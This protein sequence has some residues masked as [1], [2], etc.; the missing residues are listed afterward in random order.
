LADTSI[1]VGV[2]MTHVD[3]KMELEG[4]VV[5]SK[6]AGLTGPIDLANL[7]IADRP[8][9]DFHADFYKPVDQDGLRIG[10][11]TGSLCGGEI[12][13]NVDL[14]FPET[15]DSRYVM[16]LVLR[17]ADVR[18][19]SG[20]KDENLSGELSVTMSLEGSWP[21]PRTRRGRGDVQVTGKEMYK[22]PLVLGLLQITN[23]SLPITAPFTDGQAFY[24][25]DGQSVTFERLE[26]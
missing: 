2:P 16:E 3:G 14:T 19:I 21:A 1:D 10:K 13:G 4:N 20:M 26:L 9:R 24:S 17:N 15:A 5:A 22:I 18:D 25:V 12:A 8:A 23:L 6:L 7:Q 11:I